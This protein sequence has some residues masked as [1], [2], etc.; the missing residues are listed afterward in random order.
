MYG[1][2]N[3][4]VSHLFFQCKGAE[5][6]WN[7]FHKW[8]GVSNVA[9]KQV[10]HNFYHFVLVDLTKSEN[11]FWKVIW[12][13]MVREV[14]EQSNRVMFNNGT[15]KGEEIFGGPQLKSWLWIIDKCL[16]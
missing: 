2:K 8:I 10:E 11:K 9:H 6:V 7:L 16:I 15:V 12:M 13:A 1:L 3:E 14:W 5:V 4:Y